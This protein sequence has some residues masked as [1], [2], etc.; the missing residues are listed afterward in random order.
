MATPAGSHPASPPAIPGKAAVAAC[1]A[2][3]VFYV[4]VLYAPT[5][6]LR[7]PPATSLRAF[8]HRRFVCAAVSSAASVLATAALLGV[9]APFSPSSPH[10][11]PSVC[12]SEGISN[13]LIYLATSQVWSLSDSSKALAVLGIRSDHLVI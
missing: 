5:P 12:Y 9:S 4:A 11:S 6:L 1:A 10:L 7:L 2:M 13:P 3:A 8:F